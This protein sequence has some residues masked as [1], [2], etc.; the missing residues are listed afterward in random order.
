MMMVLCP[1]AGLVVYLSE[2]S[3]SS[4]QDLPSSFPIK[5]KAVNNTS[6]P[7][8]HDTE[9]NELMSAKDLESMKRCGSSK[10]CVVKVSLSPAKAG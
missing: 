2:Q 7:H 5:K 8:W 6:L 10:C 3:A 1:L 9:V 4:I